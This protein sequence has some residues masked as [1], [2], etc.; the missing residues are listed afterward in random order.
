[1]AVTKPNKD[2]P[3]PDDGAGMLT[4]PK[5]GHLPFDGQGKSL[6]VI[7]N[8][9]PPQL[10]EEVYARLGDRADFEVVAQLDGDTVSPEHPMTLHVLGSADMRTV[11][12]VVNSHVPDDSYGMDEQERRVHALKERLIRG[13][14]LSEQELNTL[15][16]A[17]V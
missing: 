1:M 3:Q 10:I 9:N 8:V 13:E 5:G 14:D 6:T 17:M 7:K 11:L 16:R 4:P 15:M 2:E 12:G